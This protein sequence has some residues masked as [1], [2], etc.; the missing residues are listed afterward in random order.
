MTAEQQGHTPDFVTVDLR[1]T[2]PRP[3]VVARTSFHGLPDSKNYV[4]IH[5]AVVSICKMTGSEGM[6]IEEVPDAALIVRSVN[7]H[8]DMLAAC[9]AA[10]KFLESNLVEPGRTIFWQLVS[11]IAKAEGRSS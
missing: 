7:C 5:N 3:W 1:G 11:S 10:K 2:T 9:K 4:T 6:Q 8:D